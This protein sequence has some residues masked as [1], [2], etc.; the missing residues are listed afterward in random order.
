MKKHTLGVSLIEVMVSLVLSSFLIL[1]VTKIYLD[2]KKTDAYLHAYSDVQNN[3][4]VTQI[5]LERWIDRAGY[6]RSVS[7][8]REKSF[9]QRSYS[10][11]D[12][13]CDFPSGGSITNIKG[14]D[15]FCI[16][17]QAISQEEVDCEGKTVIDTQ[18]TNAFTEPNSDSLF[19]QAIFTKK[20]ADGTYA[21]S[22][23][24]PNRA[25]AKLIELLPNIIDF[26][27]EFGWADN[28][29]HDIERKVTKFSSPNDWKS[30]PNKSV[31]AIR[32]YFLISS[33]L[34]KSDVPAETI[35]EE[36]KTIN[37]KFE[38]KKLESTRILE[39]VNSTIVARNLM[40]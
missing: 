37:P 34:N 6:Q 22:C 36:W 40:P 38:S 23:I 10:A 30:N 3:A 15:G 29:L 17:Y 14:Q 5:L 7:I 21:L 39:I 24:N 12:I 2:N 13:T 19:V 16:R 33:S 9:P 27:M 8:A 28:L 26:K 18:L 32:Y 20:Q 25:N 4:Q 11:Q 1:G 35:I 31:R